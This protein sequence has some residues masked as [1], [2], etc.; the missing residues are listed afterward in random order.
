MIKQFLSILFCIIVGYAYPQTAFQKVFGGGNAD[1]CNDAIQTSDNGFVMVGQTN[2]FGAGAGD[3]Y[4]V[5][6]DS[7]GSILWTKTYGGS[8]DESGASIQ[9][10]NDHGFIITGYTFSFGNGGEDVY[11]IRT[12]SVGDTLWTA[13]FGGPNH[14]DE[15]TCIQQTNDGG[16][17]F[18]GTTY[19]FGQGISDVYLVKMDFAG[20]ITWV[21]TFGDTLLDEGHYVQQTSD[22]G[23]IIIG[24]TSSF[25]PY[26]TDIY[27]IKTDGLGNLQW[28]YAY[29]GN[30]IDYGYCV[31]Q[32]SDGGFILVGTTY[33]FGYGNGDIYLIKT[34]ANGLVTWSRTYGGTNFDDG[35]SVIQTSDGGYL[36]GGT[37]SNYIGGNEY[38]C[39]VKTDGYGNAL[40]AKSYGGNQSSNGNSISQTNEGGYLIGGNTN[41]YGSGN[42]DLFLIKIDPWNNDLCSNGNLNLGNTFPSTASTFCFTISGPP[43]QQMPGGAKVHA[44]TIVGNGGEDN[45]IC[46]HVGIDEL[47]GNK[48]KVLI[49]P[50]PGNNNA[51]INISKTLINSSSSILIQMFDVYGRECPIEF[52]KDKSNFSYNLNVSELPNGPYIC[53]VTESGIIIAGTKVIIQK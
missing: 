8:Q 34:D 25:R 22:G 30:N 46:Y 9:Q 16:F 5:K 11:L 2:S 50:N 52:S 38:V 17:I 3:V 19:S 15:G 12:D 29:G 32:T 33:S 10:T 14:Y 49:Y 40:W 51:T 23:Y 7:T 24:N 43:A 27:L 20:N 36:I 4:V 18:T 39:S 45:S 42:S 26:N 31:K 53:K 48:I 28:S 37:T 13:A 44:A 41:S 21:K 35:K 1:I 47:N 6:C